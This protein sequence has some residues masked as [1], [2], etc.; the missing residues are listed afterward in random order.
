MTTRE[1]RGPGRDGNRRGAIAA[2][3]Q[4]NPDF[5][6]RHQALA[7]RGC[8]SRTRAAARRSRWSSARSRSCARSRRRWR[9]NLRSWCAWRAPTTP[10]PR[11]CIASRGGCC[12]AP[13]GAQSAHDRSQPARGLRR[14]SRGAG[15]DWRPPRPRA[16]AVRALDRERRCRAQVLR[17]A[18][19]QRQAAVWPGA[20]SQREFLFGRMPA[21]SAPWRW[22]R[23]CRRGIRPAPADGPLGVLALGSTDRDRF[24]PGMSTEFLAR[25]ADL[26]SDSVSS[27]L[28]AR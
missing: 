7:A 21:T 2:Y 12:A 20:R 4:H 9:T 14:L 26:I 28:P 10:L 27:S 23:S 24:H 18:V 16:A 25:M 22:C 8:G 1:A 6:E 11:G 19:R 17:H 13:S 3:L 15:V 5:F